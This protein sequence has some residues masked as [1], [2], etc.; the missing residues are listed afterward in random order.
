M[1]AIDC[2]DGGA[3]T[4]YDARADLVPASF[5]DQGIV[6]Q[7]AVESAEDPELGGLACC[8]SKVIGNA[9]GPAVSLDIL[10]RPGKKG[11]LDRGVFQEAELVQVVAADFYA[12]CAGS[13]AGA[14]FEFAALIRNGEAVVE[15]QDI[16]GITGSEGDG[17][18]R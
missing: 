17:K 12:H 5:R 2:V 3:V 10:L 7:L 9:Y 16:V 8:E 1:P 14:E 15:A 13:F 18:E 4:A 11:A 6:G